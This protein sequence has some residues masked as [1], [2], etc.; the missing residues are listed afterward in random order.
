MEKKVLFA[1]DGSEKGFKALSIVGNLVKDQSDVQLILYHCVQQLAGLSPGEICTDVDE[2]CK[3]PYGAQEKVGNAVL[4]EA[5]RHLFATGFPEERAQTKLK[6]NS[7]DPAG[8]ILEEA[9]ASKIKTIAVGRHGRSQLE[10]LLIGS[11]SGKVAQY[12]QHRTVWVVD[13][14]VHETRRVM[15]A[16]EGTPDSDQLIRYSSEFVASN[17]SLKYTFIHL[18]PPVPPTFWDDGHILANTE[19]KDRQSR[20]EKWR[21]EW[22]ERVEGLMGEARK[23]LVGQG[24][25]ETKIETFI[26]PTKEGVARD[27]LNEIDEHEF[28]MVL[29]GKKSFRERKPFLMG[30]HANKVLQ[31]VKGSILCLIDT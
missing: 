25:P 29:M 4:E 26:L 30:S 27:L 12:A 6:I 21:S 23:A 8:D 28:Q 31:N 17:P 19:Q 5:K 16:M 11:V 14:P 20:I 22:T 7:T 13:T 9:D 18:M 10:T 2:S 3:L 15:V 24:V 1:V